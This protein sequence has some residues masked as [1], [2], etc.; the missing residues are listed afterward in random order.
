MSACLHSKSVKGPQACDFSGFLLISEFFYKSHFASR[1]Q[2]KKGVAYIVSTKHLVSYLW[3]C[4]ESVHPPKV[5]IQ[6]VQGA[7]FMICCYF[8]QITPLKG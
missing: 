5:Y 6:E 4:G 8:C 7:F 3:G 2:G 1:Y